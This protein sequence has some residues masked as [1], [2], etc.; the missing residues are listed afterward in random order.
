MREFECRDSLSRQI[1]QSVKAIACAVVGGYDTQL[2][3]EFL[4]VLSTFLEL[5][6]ERRSCERVK[7]CAVSAKFSERKPP[8]F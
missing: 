8:L 5:P 4:G 1:A 2:Q 7:R 6:N 3:R